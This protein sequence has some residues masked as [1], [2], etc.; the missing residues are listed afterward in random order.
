MLLIPCGRDW[1]GVYPPATRPYNSGVIQSL[2]TFLGGIVNDHAN[3][4]VKGVSSSEYVKT[5]DQIGAP[6]IYLVNQVLE[7]KK[8]TEL[9][10]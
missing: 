10:Y 6:L 7:A 3:C 5:P 9:S 1:K 4:K 8:D 2:D